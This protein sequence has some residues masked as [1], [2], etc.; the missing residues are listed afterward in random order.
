MPRLG[1]F[2]S[3]DIVIYQVIGDLELLVKNT[4]LRIRELEAMLP[5]KPKK[6]DKYERSIMNPLTGKREF[7]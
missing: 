4:K 1:K 3:K 5:R 2:S 6:P 7:Y